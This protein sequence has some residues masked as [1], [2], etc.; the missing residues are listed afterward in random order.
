MKLKNKTKPTTLLPVSMC[1]GH[2]LSLYLIWH[3]SSSPVAGLQR[4]PPVHV[5]YQGHAP[6]RYRQGSR[7]SRTGNR[8]PQARGQLRRSPPGVASAGCA[9]ESWNVNYASELSC[10]L[11]GWWAG[12]P[13]GRS[14]MPSGFCTLA[15]WLQQPE[16]GPPVKGLRVLWLD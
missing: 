16:S 6:W 7:R 9:E 15:Q 14:S 8:G 12:L 1:Q 11:S 10:H 2:S 5:I 3:R 4:R 13:W